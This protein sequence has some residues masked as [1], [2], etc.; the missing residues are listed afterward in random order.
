MDEF[1]IKDGELIEYNGNGNVV[2]VPEGTEAFSWSVFYGKTDGDRYGIADRITEIHIP[3]SVTRISGLLVAGSLEGK[4]AIYLPKHLEQLEESR[5]PAHLAIYDSCKINILE[6]FSDLHLKGVKGLF[7]HT[8]DV[9]SSETGEIRYSVLWDEGGSFHTEYRKMINEAWK[10]LDNFDFDAYDGFFKNLK[11]TDLKLKQALFRLKAPYQL[12]EESKKAYISFL[13]RNAK[14]ALH[15]F[16][17]SNDVASLQLAAECGLLDKKENLDDAIL[18]AQASTYGAASM[19]FLIG[20]K[21][22][23]YENQSC[24]EEKT[25]PLTKSKPIIGSVIEFGHNPKTGDSLRWLIIDQAKEKSLILSTDIVEKMPFFCASNLNKKDFKTVSWEK[26]HLRNWLNDNFLNACFSESEKEEII[27]NKL[28]PKDAISAVDYVFILNEKLFKRLLIFNETLRK[29]LN[30]VKKTEY[31][32]DITKGGEYTQ[33][34]K[35]TGKG[36]WERQI[37]LSYHKPAGVRPAMWVKNK[38]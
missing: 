35:L 3:D 2:N 28:D 5:L 17:E 18:F 36:E 25:L 4:H 10:N 14:K 11:T 23:H 31:L 19:Q 38:K 37:C 22:D 12:S 8:I 20:W 21:K 29:K 34:F 33:G 6:C 24:E 30:T 7:S 16:I 1:V 26:S 13:K 32:R 9:L 27:A 15:G